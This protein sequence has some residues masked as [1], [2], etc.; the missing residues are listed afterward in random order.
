MG[1]NRI[2]YACDIG[3]T[4]CS[5]KTH[6]PS[7]AWARLNPENGTIQ[8][9]SYI[10]K[11]IQQLEADIRQGC[12]IA[13]G[14]EAPLFIPVP[15]DWK[16]LSKGREGEGNRSFASQL[17]LTV[18][19]LGIHQSAWILRNLYESSSHKCVFTMDWQKH[20]PPRNHRPVLF[21]WEAFVSGSAH[22]EQHL[23]DAATTVDFFYR[24]EM[25]LEDARAKV[26]AEKPLSLIGCVALWSGWVSD[27]KI[28]HESTLVIKPKEPFR[29]NYRVLD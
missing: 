25:Y 1:Q 10:E 19:A 15:E 7:F 29:G 21:C 9:S 6:L 8:V 4:R 24:H 23:I 11:L 5:T 16:D 2:I 14:F 28:L 22:S 20:W 12:S 18:C 13:L 27:S 3:T 17:G 26:Y